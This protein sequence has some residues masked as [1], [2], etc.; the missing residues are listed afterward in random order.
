MDWL[1][2]EQAVDLLKK[3]GL[4][5]FVTIFTGVVLWLLFRKK[6][7]IKHWS[8]LPLEDEPPSQSKRSGQH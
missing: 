8:N 2:T 4:V 6:S 3:V 1:Q 7:D 5:A